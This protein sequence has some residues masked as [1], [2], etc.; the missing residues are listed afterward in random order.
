MSVCCIIWFFSNAI[1]ASQMHIS[2]GNPAP[3]QQGSNTNLAQASLAS[4]EP[5]FT[6]D[7][8]DADPA[9][10]D[11]NERAQYQ[12]AREYLRKYAPVAIAEQRK[13]GIPASITL[14]QGLLESNAGNSSLTKRSNNHF[15]IKC[16]SRNCKRG[17]CVNATDDTHKD[18][19][20]VYSSA[21]QSYRAHSNFLKN[22]ARY[23]RCFQCGNDYR[24][25]ADALQAAGYATAQTYSAQLQRNIQLYSLQKLDKQ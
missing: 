22:T 15:G 7:Q 18:F 23:K 10:M 6:P 14:A 12:S 3:V 8:I 16:F 19:F 17:H 5:V 4:T 2:F 21:W 13:F 9:Q 1:E 25:W 20:L 24:C 11:A